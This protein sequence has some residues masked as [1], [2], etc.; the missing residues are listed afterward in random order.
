M[1]SEKDSVST[2]LELRTEV[3][4]LRPEELVYRICYARVDLR[5]LLQSAETRSK[6]RRLPSAQ[7]FFSLKELDEVE[8][9]RL[10]LHLTEEQWTGILDLD[11]WSKDRVHLTRFLYRMS[12]VIE[13]EDAVARKLLRGPDHELFELALNPLRIHELDEDGAPEAEQGGGLLETPDHHFLVELPEN[14][15]EA[16]LLKAFILR[17]YQLDGEGAALLLQESHFRTRSEMEEQA[18]QNRKRRVE[19][20]GFQ[21]YYDAI[22]I[23]ALLPLDA[24]LPLKTREKIREVSELPLASTELES[25][26]ML[27]IAALAGFTRPL[28]MEALVEELFFVCNKL[29]CADRISPDD[30]AQVKRGILKAISGINLGLDCWSEGNLRVAE[31]G[32]SKHYLQSFFRLGYSQIMALQEEARRIQS[33]PPEPEPGSFLEA[34]LDGLLES[35]P[36]FTE[37]IEGQI[38]R[39]F[40]ST[41]DDLAAARVYL[42]EIQDPEPSRS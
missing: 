39:R 13:S 29:L 4:A 8:I 27:F 1:A 24:P 21:D 15:D 35:Y 25:G 10:L 5:E 7:L 11:L 38:R 2:D 6:I 23:Y 34:I 33:E 26:S 18:Y 41:R 31:E 32:L 42:S 20:M 37:L 9:Q 22:E 36:V 40:F 19:D 28:E 12:H 30:P 16:S 14:A 3:P 17:L